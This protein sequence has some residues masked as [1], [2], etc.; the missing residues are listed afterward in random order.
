[1]AQT[2]SYNVTVNYMCNKTYVCEGK[3]YVSH[4]SMSGISPSP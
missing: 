3:I 4:H 1:M 2:T